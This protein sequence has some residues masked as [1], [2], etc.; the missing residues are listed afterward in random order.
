MF[1]DNQYPGQSSALARIPSSFSFALR[2]M[3]DQDSALPPQLVHPFFDGSL[4]NSADEDQAV[5]GYHSDYHGPN[6]HSW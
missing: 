5:Y 4:N 2:R 6:R 1:P 3:P